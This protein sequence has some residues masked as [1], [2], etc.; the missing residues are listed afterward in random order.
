MPIDEVD[1]QAWSRFHDDSAQ[2]VVPSAPRTLYPKSLDELI[3]ICATRAPADHIHAAGSHWALSTAAI[4][5]RIF[6]ETHDPNEQHQVMGKTLYEVVPGAL[7]QAF[8]AALAA[9]DPTDDSQIA[10]NQGFYP[11]HIET[12]KR[13]YQL[14]SELDFGDKDSRSLATQLAKG[15]KTHYL[16][17][18]WG[19]A[20]LGGAGGQTV[21]GALT[22]GTHGGDFVMA[23]IA[24]GVLALHLV[25]D[26]GNHYWIERTSVPGFSE[27]QLTDDTLLQGVYGG[28]GAPGSFHIVRDDDIFNAVVV[29][30]GR[31]GIVYS[32]VLRAVRQYSLHE[33]RRLSTWNTVKGQINDPNSALYITTQQTTPPKLGN[34]FLQVAISVPPI[35]AFTDHSVGITKH[36]NLTALNTAGRAERRGDPVN[37]GAIDP[38]LQA[39]RFSMAGNNFA[40]A[41]SPNFLDMACTDGNLIIGLLEEGIQEIADWVESNGAVISAA[42]AAVIAAGFGAELFTLFAAILAVL[43][44][45]AGILAALAASGQSRLGQVINDVS[46]ALLNQGIAGVFI[47]QVL[48]QK[49]FADQQKDRDVEGL[50]YA[51]MDGHNYLDRSCTVNAD[52]IEVFFDATDPILIAFVDAV[53]DFEIMQEVLFQRTFAGYISLRFTQQTQTLIGEQRWPVTCA[54]EISGLRDV[55]GVTDLIN[56]AMMLALNPH[57]GA[58]MHWGQHNISS[59]AQVEQRF[60]DTPADPTGDLHTWRQA[61]STITDNGRLN[62]FTSAFTRQTGLEI[63]TPVITSLTITGTRSGVPITVFWDASHNPPGTSI[64]LQ[65]IAPNGTTTRFNGLALTGQQQATASAVNGTYTMNLSASISLGGETITVV[66]QAQVTIT[67]VIP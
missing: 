51:I 44:I 47:W 45:L 67:T 62:G 63:V 32:I 23:P 27:T 17:A 26:G 2:P 52:S 28:R 21:F 41:S 53:L 11:I 40:F 30:A 5:D 19:F 25:A 4:S 58:V 1:G 37:N 22:T 6:V 14:Y 18:S 15:G 33:E 57:F 39:V 48:A 64:S 9:I 10:V 20:T 61:L 8:I 66:R 13:I 7:N 42:I 16:D 34:R 54:I 65:V 55:A 50:S 38:I 31:F 56:Y 43:A 24:D 12:G 60:G 49:I 29:G 3:Q 59:R 46:Q 36:W 35:N